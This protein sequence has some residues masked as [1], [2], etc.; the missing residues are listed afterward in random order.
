M[1]EPFLHPPPVPYDNREEHSNIWKEKTGHCDRV[2]L[3]STLWSDWTMCCVDRENH[4]NSLLQGR[5]S[6]INRHRAASEW[7]KYLTGCRLLSNKPFSDF[8]IICS[9][10]RNV[11]LDPQMKSVC[12]NIGKWSD[13]CVQAL[14][15]L[16][17]NLRRG[18]LAS[19]CRYKQCK[20]QALKSNSLCKCLM[21][22]V[23]HS[24]CL[25]QALWWVTLD[26]NRNVLWSHKSTS[27]SVIARV[28]V[29]VAAV[30]ACS[31]LLKRLKNHT[32]LMV[33][34]QLLARQNFTYYCF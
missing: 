10:S 2:W 12:T 3:A 24:T 34:M 17:V 23:M 30:Q 6:T 21:R 13:F 25:L 33:T 5:Y 15:N 27:D 20:C 4:V 18:L 22:E 32:N 1:W 19:K 26:V 28:F 7:I 31:V 16:N 9:D 14:P 11:W 8:L 29:S